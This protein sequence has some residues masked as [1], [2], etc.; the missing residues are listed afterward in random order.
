MSISILK[1]LLRL[2]KKYGHCCAYQ[3]LPKSYIGKWGSFCTNICA[4]HK[5]DEKEEFCIGKEF[6]VITDPFERHYIIAGILKS[7]KYI[8]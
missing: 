3:L 6:Q 4:F 8:K 7:I 1:K 2:F 5:F